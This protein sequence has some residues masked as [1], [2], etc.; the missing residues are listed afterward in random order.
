MSSFLQRIR[1]SVEDHFS[2]DKR[3]KIG[4][5]VNYGS[6]YSCI[7]G[8]PK[9][10]RIFSITDGWTANDLIYKWKSQSPVQMVANLSLPGGFKMDGFDNEIC[11]V[12]T[13]T[14]KKI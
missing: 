2:F 7:N 4:Y 1:C 10:N 8:R 9:P 13:A 6:F 12:A 3:S 14:G 5:A 11:D